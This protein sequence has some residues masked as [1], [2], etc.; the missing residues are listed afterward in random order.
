MAT[1]TFKCTKK[2]LETEY[3]VFLI[4]EECENCPF[5]ATTCILMGDSDGCFSDS[6]VCSIQ[7]DPEDTNSNDMAVIDPDSCELKVPL[8]ET[9]LFNTQNVQISS[10]IG[11]PKV[12]F[13]TL[14]QY[15]I[16]D[17]SEIHN[18]K[19]EM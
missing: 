16:V 11:F 19:L 7:N 6:M 10:S 9:K 14:V 1:F 8:P 17:F 18:W 3:E 12:F 2:T 15:P 13:K 5:D 4:G